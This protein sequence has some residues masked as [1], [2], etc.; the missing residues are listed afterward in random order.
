MTVI[1]GLTVL[2][3][4]TMEPYVMTPSVAQFVTSYVQLTW[5][6]AGPSSLPVRHLTSEYLP[7]PNHLSLNAYHAP[8]TQSKSSKVG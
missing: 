1:D 5:I 8:K 2:I 7:L 6:P 3:D 4:L